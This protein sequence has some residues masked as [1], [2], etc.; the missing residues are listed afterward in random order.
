MEGLGLFIVV[1]GGVVLIALLLRGLGMWWTGISELIGVAKS[2]DSKLPD[3]TRDNV[4][5]KP[6][7]KNEIEL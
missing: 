6:V 4:P 3:M 7:V 1:F 5:D 2:I